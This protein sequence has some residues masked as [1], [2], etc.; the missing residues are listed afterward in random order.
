MIVIKAKNVSDALMQ[1][2]MTLMAGELMPSRAGNV[3]VAPCPVMIETQY[4]RERVLRTAV[5]DANPFFHLVEAIWMLGGRNDAALLSRFV[6]DFGT[7]FAESD[8]VIHGAYGHRWRV[9]QG[10]DQL[11]RVI[12]MLTSNPHDRQAVIQ[13]WDGLDVPIVLGSDYETAVRV[14]SNDLQGKW[15]DRPCNTHIYL[16]VQPP[17]DLEEGPRLDM[18]VCCR[19]ND[20]IWGAHGANAVHFSVLQ[21]YLAARIGVE[22]GTMYQLANNY[23]AYVQVFDAIRSKCDVHGMSMAVALGLD[24]YQSP[25]FGSAPDVMFD[26]PQ[27]ADADIVRFLEWMDG[28]VNRELVPQYSNTFFATTLE[29]MMVAHDKYKC[30]DFNGAEGTAEMIEADDWRTACVEWLQRRA[31]NRRKNN[32]A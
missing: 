19:S 30:G 26:Q 10:Y 25:D 31:D 20:A 3:L 15:S 28:D 2:M 11:E 6:S 5:R 29:P 18:T 23:H 27:H 14:G 9:A 7:R 17:N 1:G 12:E 22:V 32:A 16:R 4:P 21:E 8:G 13:M 24:P